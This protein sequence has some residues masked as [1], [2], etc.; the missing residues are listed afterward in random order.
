MDDDDDTPGVEPTDYAMD[1]IFARP[2][3][4]PGGHGDVLL[5][6]PKPDA[7]ADK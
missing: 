6:A 1:D 3:G 2:V 7:S 5:P 4:K